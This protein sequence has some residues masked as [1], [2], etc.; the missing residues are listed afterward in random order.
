MCIKSGKV[1]NSGLFLE[2]LTPSLCYS[3]IYFPLSVMIQSLENP[4]FPS[5]LLFYLGHFILVSRTSRRAC[6]VS[7][8]PHTQR[9]SL[10][11]HPII[12]PGASKPGSAMAWMSPSP[13][14]SWKIRDTYSPTQDTAV[15]TGSFSLP[16]LPSFTRL[17]T[18][19]P[20][21]SHLSQERNP[22]YLTLLP[23][24]SSVPSCDSP[25]NRCLREKTGQ[26]NFFSSPNSKIFFNCC[27]T[28]D[29]KQ[30]LYATEHVQVTS[31]NGWCQRQG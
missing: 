15:R 19:S 20:H 29:Y 22:T 13:S 25:Q 7:F 28:V 27:N 21:G 8:P 24:P 14:P 16:F 26:S 1:R 3:R 2:L 31:W 17:F 30:L 11:Y 4:N 12:M 5:Y 6:C 10:L 18:T 9:R 23:I